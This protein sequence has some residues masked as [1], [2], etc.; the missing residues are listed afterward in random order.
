MNIREHIFDDAAVGVAQMHDEG[1][2]ITLNL[3][4]SHQKEFNFTVGDVNAMKKY[5]DSIMGTKIHLT[6]VLDEVIIQMR[7]QGCRV[8]DSDAIQ[9]LRTTTFNYD[10]TNGVTNVTACLDNV[11]KHTS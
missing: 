2:Y 3:D 5:F 7:K 8:N 6:Y 10:P 11:Y 9:A 1:H 4:G